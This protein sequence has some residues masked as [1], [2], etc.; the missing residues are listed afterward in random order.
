MADPVAGQPAPG[1]EWQERPLDRGKNDGRGGEEDE[2]L[3][4]V[5]SHGVVSFCGWPF[6]RARTWLRSTR[7]AVPGDRSTSA[8]MVFAIPDTW[9]RGR[10]V[11]SCRWVA[12]EIIRACLP[13][14]FRSRSVRSSCRLAALRRRRRRV[15]RGMGAVA[16]RPG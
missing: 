15:V 13:G 10:V 9:L 12:S 2:D 14:G 4:G 8:P 7:R 6:C 16:L 1:H 5:V 11:R 3:D